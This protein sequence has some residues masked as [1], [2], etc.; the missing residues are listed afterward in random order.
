MNFFNKNYEAIDKD[1]INIGVDVFAACLDIFDELERSSETEIIQ[2]WS[3]ELV[4]KIVKAKRLDRNDVLKEGLDSLFFS[5]NRQK[6][7]T[8][9]K[10]GLIFCLS[11]KTRRKTRMILDKKLGQEI[12]ELLL[13]LYQKIGLL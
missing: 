9:M 11:P 13:V 2:K 12:M 4:E 3:I 7:A 8:P 10:H 5:N 6:L 1:T